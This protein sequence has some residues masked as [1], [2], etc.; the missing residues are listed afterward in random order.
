MPLHVIQRGHNRGVIYFEDADYN[1]FLQR[2]GES[3]SEHGCSIH[4]YVLMTNHVHLL[5]T[6]QA[7]D[8]AS[9]MMK[10]LNQRYVRYVNRKYER[11]GT[12]W[13]GRFRS[14]LTQSDNYVLACYRYIELNPVRGGIVSQ[15]K[16]Y[17]WSSYAAN[18]KGWSN[19]LLTPHS[20]YLALAA[21]DEERRR[22]YRKLVQSGLDEDTLVRIRSATNSNRVLGSVRFEKEIAAMV[23]TKNDPSHPAG[24]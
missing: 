17:R 14:C 12:L 2:L 19:R 5:L 8:S 20:V 10:H 23:A 15:P 4:A 6:P 9:L 16:Q 18:A 24:S 11:S 3:A 22:C 21:D 1:Y 7:R 13:E